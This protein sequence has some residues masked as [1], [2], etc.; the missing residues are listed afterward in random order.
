MWGSGLTGIHIYIKVLIVDDDDNIVGKIVLVKN[1]RRC[2]SN[3]LD[4]GPNTNV[5]PWKVTIQHRIIQ[6]DVHELYK[7]D[8]MIQQSLEYKSEVT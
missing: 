6:R 5:R 7:R 3:T 2:W 8:E 1:K 4:T